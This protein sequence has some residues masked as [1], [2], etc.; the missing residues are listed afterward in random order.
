MADVPPVR[1]GQRLQV[2][3]RSQ[4]LAAGHETGRLTATADPAAGVSGSDMVWICVGTPSGSDG[5]I[6][7]TAVETVVGQIGR[8]L[9]TCP[10]RPLVVLRSTCLP[11]SWPIKE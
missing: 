1:A 7:L 11:G 8:L 10:D 9:R 5:A 3:A 6:D 2:V 4:L